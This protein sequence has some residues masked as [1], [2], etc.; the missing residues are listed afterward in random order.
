[1]SRKILPS[2]KENKFSSERINY[3]QSRRKENG[4]SE[5][6]AVSRG[7]INQ[8]DGRNCSHERRN[9]LLSK[10]D[11]LTVE[12]NYSTV[13]YSTVLSSQASRENN[14]LQKRKYCTVTKG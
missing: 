12:R 5:E 11:L 7:E 10:G 3:F 1:V 4:G 14:S 13:Q 2:V 6:I 9:K 8:V